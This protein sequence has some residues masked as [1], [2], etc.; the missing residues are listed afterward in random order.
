MEHPISGGY[1]CHLRKADDSPVTPEDLEKLKDR[2]REIVA[3]NIPFHRYDAPTEK[4]IELFRK[5]GRDDKV[6]L[7]ETSGEVYMDYY[8]LG[9][10]PDYYYGRLVPSA[11]YLTVWD[12]RPY[13]DGLLLQLPDP[14]DPS[15]LTPFVDQPK[16][17][18]MFKEN[19]RWNIIMGLSTVGDVNEACQHGQA[20][21]LIRVAEALQEKKIVQIAEEIDRRYR[22]SPMRLVLITGPSSSG[23]TT[24]CKRLSVQLKACGLRP[25][26]VSTDDYFVNRLDTPRLP[27]GSF[28][29]DNFDTVDHALMQSDLLK[30]LSGEEV[31]VPEFNFVTGLRDVGQ[32]QDLDRRCRA[33]L[34]DGLA[35]IVGHQAD[36]ALLCIRRHPAEGELHV[37]RLRIVEDPDLRTGFQRTDHAAV[38]ARRVVQQDRQVAVVRLGDAHAARRVRRAQVGCQ[39]IAEV[40]ALIGADAAFQR[41]HICVLFLRD[42]QHL[43]FHAFSERHVGIVFVSGI[44]VEKRI[45]SRL[46]ERR[47]IGYAG[48]RCARKENQVFGRLVAN[49]ANN[50][51]HADPI[52]FPA[53]TS[54]QKNAG[55][56]VFHRHD[57]F[58]FAAGS[59]VKTDAS[60]GVTAHDDSR[61]CVAALCQYRQAHISPDLS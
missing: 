56:A 21:D 17:F 58:R 26:S 44:A 12:I 15:K 32:A 34:L 6:K 2:M 29:F 40:A 53:R 57:F 20:S 39:D 41:P 51:S 59:I 37:F 35:L 36:A 49:P 5:N 30:I 43:D 28:D 19:L 25:I 48:T 45:P 31:S 54:E 10:T 14:H 16:T 52:P 8:I 47:I 13:Y 61:F 1:F 24:F 18:D 11:G 55:S 9:D 7:L 4:T 23:K 22:E 50:A 46:H 27:D 38:A 33:G 60:R 3:K 42:A